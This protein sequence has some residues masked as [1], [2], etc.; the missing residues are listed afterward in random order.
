MLFN[1]IEFF[2]LL[3]LT[4]G[5]YYIV[6]N[7]G[8]QIGVLVASSLVFYAWHTP[9]LLILFLSSVLLNLSV[10]YGVV[11]GQPHRRKLLATIGVVLNLAILAFF[12]YSPLIGKSLFAPGSDAFEF[13]VTIP[14]PIGISF[15]T[16]E[17][18][19]L[20]VDA[21][22]GRDAH[23][24]QGIIPRSITRHAA[25]TTLFVAF[26]PHLISGPILKAHDFIPQIGSKS[27]E[28]IDW[29]YV[30][31]NVVIG[32]F[33]KMVLADNLNQQTFWMDFPYFQ[34]YN[35]FVLFTLLFGYSMQ[36][37][38]DFAGYSMIAVG[39]AGL[40]GYKLIQNFNFPYISASFK[41]FWK[42]WHISLSSFL[43]EYLYFP[44]GGNRKGKVRTY[45]NL[46][47]TMALG[48]L[49]HGAAWSYMVWGFFHGAALAVERLLQDRR[50]KNTSP[51][52]AWRQG[53]SMVLVFLYVTFCWLLFRLPAFEHVLLYLKAMFGNIS[54]PVGGSDMAI[55]GYIGLY[56][57]PVIAWHI[58]YLL[59]D[60]GKVQWL[61][62]WEPI[63]YAGMLF[64]ILTNSGV[65][66]S[67][68]YFQ[69]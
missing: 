59:R 16:F 69:F 39:I 5:L 53:L 31:K 18:I 57:I 51:A 62:K 34:S 28:D 48:G 30:F 19:S 35:S 38:A 1:S 65:G 15:F 49:W 9:A 41:D 60:A 36:I 17:G 3:V 37:F 44:L 2:Y 6:R 4:F 56:S 40:F 54:R 23:E 52:P 21:Y 42:R 68:I 46:L 11:Y 12:K 13:L 29:V 45:V 10:S 66:A 55:I 27:F 47:L 24:Y 32:F 43:M 22:K 14:L 25:Q 33:L 67:F 63:L 26:F 58:L 8:W 50:G 20:V 7:R 61:T 64:L